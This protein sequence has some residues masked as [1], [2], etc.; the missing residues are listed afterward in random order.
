MI[1][2]PTCKTC[3]YWQLWDPEINECHRHAPIA[4]YGTPQ[5]ADARERKFA[6]YPFTAD[7][8]WCGDHPDFPSHLAATRSGAVSPEVGNPHPSP[9]VP[10]PAGLT[11]PPD[12]P[13][14]SIVRVNFR[15][16]ET[17]MDTR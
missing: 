12:V 17:G 15:Q 9:P 16:G 5:E 3:P 4:Y 8:D 2:R 14:G 7:N 10:H 1:K 13:A 11:L 6:I